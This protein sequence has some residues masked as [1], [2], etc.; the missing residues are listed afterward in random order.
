VKAPLDP[1]LAPEDDP[2]PDALAWPSHVTRESFFC[3]RGLLQ[4]GHSGSW[5]DS[6]K[7]SCFSNSSP[8]ALHL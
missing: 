6:E 2:P 1:Q 5:S 8:Q 4:V 3:V 7:R